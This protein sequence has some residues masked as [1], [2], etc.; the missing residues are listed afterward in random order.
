MKKITAGLLSLLVI[1]FIS[2]QR[3]IDWGLGGSSATDKLLVKIKS[4][5]GVDSSVILYS[6]NTARQ[7]IGENITGMSG[8]TNL[9]NDLKIFRNN[10]GII[11]KTVQVSATLVAAGVDSVVTIYNY[12]TTA[13]QYKSSVFTI[14]VFGFSVT[15]SA[16]Y[17]YDASGK[18]TG[19]EHYLKTGFLPPLLSLKNQYSYSADGLNLTGLQQLASLVP[20]DPLTPVSAQTFTYD[21]KKNPLII[22]NEAVLLGRT[23]FF[24]A[25]NGIKIMLTST[26]SPANDFTTDYV[27][28]YNSSGQPDSSY[29]TR[30]PG[31]SVT[32]SKYFYQ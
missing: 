29:A 12:N 9:G 27:Y 11:L 19:D 24:N 25:N 15:D 6:Y 1:L 16:A 7:L 22:K 31:G 23:G 18:I 5:T 10:S 30:T 17:T 21:N 13:S 26:I 4:K 3:E 8:T 2:C 14:T 32:A 20:G 28:K